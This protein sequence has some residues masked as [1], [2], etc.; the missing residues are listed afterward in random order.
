MVQRSGQFEDLL[1]ALV[2]TF[3]IQFRTADRC[4]A[5]EVGRH[6]ITVNAYAPGIIGKTPMCEF[7]SNVALYNVVIFFSGEAVRA[8]FA[9]GLGLQNPDAVDEAVRH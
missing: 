8:K 4:V 9:D 6:G 5:K 1:L 2:R 7:L 3:L